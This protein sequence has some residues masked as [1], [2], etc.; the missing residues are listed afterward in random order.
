MLIDEITRMVTGPAA[1]H[2]MVNDPG[3]DALRQ[4]YWYI[5]APEQASLPCSSALALATHPYWTLAGNPQAS[6]RL[7]R[8]INEYSLS[9]RVQELTGEMDTPAWVTAQQR[10]L[11]K[12]IGDLATVPKTEVDKN[13]EQGVLD[14]LKFT[15]DLVAKYAKRGGGPGGDGGE[16]P[17]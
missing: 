1:L 14:A 10:S 8:L 17:P 9:S 11:E 3:G 7:A 12:T 2:D 5:F 13:R 6:E 15:S 4:L 16:I